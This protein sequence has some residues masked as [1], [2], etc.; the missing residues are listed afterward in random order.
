MLQNIHVKH[1]ISENYVQNF[2][3]AIHKI[4]NEIFMLNPIV[5]Q[6]VETKPE[7]NVGIHIRT[8]DKQIYNKDNEEFYRDYITNIFK[9][10]HPQTT[11]IFISSDCLLVFE[12]AK[13]YFDNLDYNKGCVIHTS[14]TDKINE[15]GLNKV[16]LDLL[17]LSQ[18]CKSLY[19]G[20][21]SNFSRIGALF[22]TNRRITC[23]EYDNIPGNIKEF[24]TDILFS[25]FSK[26]KYT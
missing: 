16:L 23:Y 11:S 17:M 5:I 21:N 15:E 10:I 8:G 19:I 7:Y 3:R 2:S 22:N 9:S 12:I 1:L 26:G 24:S 14:E 25:Y 18:K 6:Q 20:W 4:I 13:E